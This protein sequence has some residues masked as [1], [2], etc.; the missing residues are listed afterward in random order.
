M[1]KIMLPTICVSSQD[2]PRVS[3]NRKTNIVLQRRGKANK[4]MARI[5]AASMRE[6]GVGIRVCQV[7]LEGGSLELQSNGNVSQTRDNTREAYCSRN[8]TTSPHQVGN[9]GRPAQTQA[10]LGMRPLTN[11]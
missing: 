11:T 6:C 5:F 8:G 2:S 9:Y 1:E 10:C 4:L 3:K 7:H